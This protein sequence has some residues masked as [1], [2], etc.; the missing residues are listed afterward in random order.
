VRELDNNSRADGSGLEGSDFKTLLLRIF[1]F[2]SECVLR[3]QH[4]VWSGH[5]DKVRIS[6]IDDDE[7]EPSRYLC[8]RLYTSVTLSKCCGCLFETVDPPEQIHS[9]EEILGRRKFVT[10]HNWSMEQVLCSNQR[11]QSVAIIQGPSALKKSQILSSLVCIVIAAV[12]ITL[13]VLGFMVWAEKSALGMVLFVILIIFCCF[14]RFRTAVRFL[15]AYRRINES[16]ESSFDEGI[17]QSY[18]TY[19]V[20]RPTKTFRTILFFT[21]AGL[22]FVWPVVTL[23]KIGRYS[24][25]LQ[26]ALFRSTS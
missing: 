13:L 4:S 19:R 11:N 17:Y 8:T 20:S 5:R 9:L 15:K 14:P 22:F 25:N 26:G 2:L 3:R 16:D 18:E 7:L 24:V 21:G 6:S 10:R 23:I 12:G 1:H